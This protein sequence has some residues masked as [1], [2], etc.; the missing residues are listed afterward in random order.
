MLDLFV[1]HIEMER[2][3]A[4]GDDFMPINLVFLT[5][6]AQQHRLCMH[7]NVAVGNH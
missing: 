2:V 5:T 3:T 1:S 7:A 4:Q 6:S